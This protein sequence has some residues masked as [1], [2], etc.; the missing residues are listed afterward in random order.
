MALSRLYTVEMHVQYGFRL[1]GFRPLV[2]EVSRL[3]R[4]ATRLHQLAANL[5]REPPDM[6]FR[7]DYKV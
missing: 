4:Q 2:A 6:S 1:T 5:R 3:L 7:A